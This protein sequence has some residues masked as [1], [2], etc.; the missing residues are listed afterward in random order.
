MGEAY[1]AGGFLGRFRER[2]EIRF[3]L[4]SSDI[5]SQLPDSCMDRKTLSNFFVEGNSPNGKGGWFWDEGCQ[6]FRNHT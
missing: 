3:S 1:T 2:N 6:V 4:L 5:R